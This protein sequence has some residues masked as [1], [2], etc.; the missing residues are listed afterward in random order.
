MLAALVLA[1]ALAVASA[2]LG[3]SVA[4]AVVETQL[5]H[6][7]DKIEQI[8]NRT[9]YFESNK[10]LDRDGN[11]LYEAFDE[12]RRTYVPLDDI[13]LVM[14]QATIAFEDETFYTNPGINAPS[15]ARAFLQNLG[16]GYIVSGGSTITQQLVRHVV[17]PP[18]ERFAQTY[19]R[20][21]KEALLALYLSQ[22]HSKDDVLEWY[23]NEIFYGNHSYGVQA[24]A[25]TIFGKDV[26]DVTLA[27]AALL[28]GLPPAPSTMDPLDPRPEVRKQVKAQQR[29]VLVRMVEAGYITEQQMEAAHV[30]PLVFADPA[31]D[32]F[33]YPHFVMF[34]R[35]WMEAKFPPEVIRRGGLNVT[36]SLDPHVQDI[37]QAIV[38]EHVE[39]LG[40]RHNLHNA[41]LVAMIPR[42]GE[43]L[44]MVG[45]KDY[46]DDSIDGRVNVALAER[47]PGSSFKPITY[48]R[49]L[50]EGFPT[51]TVLWDVPTR[52][53][54]GRGAFVPANYDLKFHGPVR[55]RAA[56]ANSYNIP[57][58]RMLER[59]GIG[60]AIAKAHQMGITT[61][62]E[63][64]GHYGLS[65]TLGGGEVRLLDLVTVY[66][67]L[68]NLGRRQVAQPVLRITDSQGKVLFDHRATLGQG[69][70]VA[71]PRAAYIITAILSDNSART[72]AFGANSPLRL[73][74]PAAV[75]TGTTDDFK[76]NWTLG[77]TPYL[78]AGVWAGNTRGEPLV[79]SSG[80]TGAAPMWRDFMERVFSDE[81]VVTTLRDALQA[82][83]HQLTQEFAR[84]NGLVR[85]KVC[86]LES[87]RA[88]A[89]KCERFRE[90]LFLSDAPPGTEEGLVYASV[91]AVPV[92]YTPPAQPDG[93]VPPAGVLL[94]RPG[95]DAP[96]ESVAMVTLL[97]PPD[98]ERERQEV[99]GWAPG[100]GWPV[101]GPEC[102]PDML[103]GRVDLP[104]LLGSEWSAPETA[105]AEYTISSPEAGQTV[106]GVVPVIGTAVFDPV[107][108]QYY[109]VEFGYGS[110]PSE[111]ITIGQTHVNPV[112]NGQLEVFNT[113]GLPAG[114][115]SLR[116][117]L[118]RR[119]GNLLPPYTVSLMVAR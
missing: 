3:V 85:L 68:A 77:Y 111:W 104:G 58:V 16:A 31:D 83:G 84:P 44:A 91:P 25:E 8:E 103:A 30:Q 115:Y 4:F 60:D 79:R 75:K 65:L 2:A 1:P 15:I 29:R 37:A 87:L 19:E 113:A 82:V 71:D 43:I 64:A 28:A 32:V 49:A 18:E 109:K 90:E 72:P 118:V 98:D 102:T 55:M 114:E 48:L 76:D 112:L 92:I 7:L 117:A 39:R 9:D 5:R 108:I 20:K 80:V 96:I 21:V 38:R 50:E 69:E 66:A 94:C 89:S 59:V 11:L 33:R 54:Q 27:E 74:R 6:E 17:F 51:S 73:S 62:Q 12:G 110:A 35:Q 10:I 70:P 93:Q 67:T 81:Q 52:Y 97:L 13:P 42:T 63:D 119:D 107:S 41:A 100:A 36:T 105:R 14:R 53:G 116:L 101:L 46:W 24:A 45:S 106:S 78:A 23:L 86:D 26:K 57:A 22:K 88:Y 61:L 34:V 99:Y 40:P 95:V 47:Q 56:L